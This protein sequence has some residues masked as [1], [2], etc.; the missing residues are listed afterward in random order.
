MPSDSQ[1]TV[2]QQRD[3]RRAEKVA[4]LKKREAITKRNRLIGGI[5]GG[6]IGLGVLALIVVLIITSVVPKPDPAAIEIEGL[7][8]FDDLV[9]AHVDGTP[10][11][12]EELYDMNPPA[13][14]DHFSAW[15]NCGVYTEV[16]QNENAVHALEHGA[17]WVTYDPEQ[18]DDDELN[19]LVGQLPSTYSLVSPFPGLPA[20]VVM[21]GWGAQL[22][23]DGVND[24]RISD[25][26]DKFWR[27]QTVPE[28]AGACT[29]AIDGPGKVA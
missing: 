6:V 26:L 19:T 17:I 9:G 15:L 28:P 21:S 20:P 23:L 10:V 5:V 7:E 11:D 13:G 8:T 29:G 24:E 4:A 12:Y 14:G 3:A 16:Q 25:F 2:K 27:A 18:I 22:E 1:L